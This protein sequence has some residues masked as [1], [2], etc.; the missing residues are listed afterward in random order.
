MASAAATGFYSRSLLELYHSRSRRHT[1]IGHGCSGADCPQLIDIFRRKHPFCRRRVWSEATDAAG[2]LSEKDLPGS[3]VLSERP[4]L[5]EAESDRWRRA[6]DGAASGQARSQDRRRS[7]LGERSLA[8]HPLPREVPAWER[9]RQPSEGT[10]QGHHKVDRRDARRSQSLLE[11]NHH[12]AKRSG[13]L[14]TSELSY[15]DGKAQPAQL[16]L[17]HSESPA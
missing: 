14:T 5:G 2:H 11:G 1:S 3:L 8:A 6:E 12:W 4:R 16:P 17:T 10:T 9:G 13:P 7:T 15:Q